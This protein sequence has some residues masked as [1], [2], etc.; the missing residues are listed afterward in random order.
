M[1]RLSIYQHVLIKKIS[2][3]NILNVDMCTHRY[4]LEPMSNT[5]HLKTMIAS[6]FVT[7]HSSLRNSSKFPVRFL[8]NLSENDLRTIHGKNLAEIS[9]LC[10]HP[11]SSLTS[12]IVKEKLCYRVVP[13]NQEWRVKMCKEVK[14]IRDNRETSLPGFTDDEINQI[15]QFLC[16][17]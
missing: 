5:L 9:R 15:L 7:F 3:W 1:L 12:K 10:D 8:A 14:S 13:D 11:V 16:V 2:V 4:L 6:R 17:S